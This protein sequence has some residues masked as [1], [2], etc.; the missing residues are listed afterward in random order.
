LFA[1][2]EGLDK[3]VIILY[4][5]WWFKYLMDWQF[6]SYQTRISSPVEKVGYEQDN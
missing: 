5:V 1:G 3:I 2:I 4:V 6:I